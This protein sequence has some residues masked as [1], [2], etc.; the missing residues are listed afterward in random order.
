MLA[1]GGD[2]MKQSDDFISPALLAVELQCCVAD[3]I[4]IGVSFF[5]DMHC[6]YA[7]FY[8]D[9]DCIGFQTPDANHQHDS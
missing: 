4:G 6:N 3:T 2:I 8:G 5:K 9:K 7:W 1:Q